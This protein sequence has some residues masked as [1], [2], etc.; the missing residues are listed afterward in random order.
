[1]T[2]ELCNYPTKSYKL[3]W[4][5]HFCECGAQRVTSKNLTA[6]GFLLE[7]LLQISDD[8]RRLGLAF[9]YNV[10]WILAVHAIQFWDF[11]YHV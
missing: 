6:N 1:M 4:E 5:I 11:N 8:L 9:Q 2:A 7:Y 10:S 3:V